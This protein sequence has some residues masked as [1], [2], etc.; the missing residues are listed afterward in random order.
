MK[1]KKNKKQ[2]EEENIKIK[3]AKK[4][5][6]QD[7]R[8]EKPKKKQH[9]QQECADTPADD[10]KFQS[11]VSNFFE[12]VKKSGEGYRPFIPYVASMQS[13]GCT[14]LNSS[15]VPREFVGMVCG[16]FLGAVKGASVFCP[17]T[18]KDKTACSEEKLKARGQ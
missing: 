13:D 3:K 12:M 18:C 11:W 10:P 6:Q 1:T 7:K 2:G 16:G 9:K 5:K 4:T 15:K 17:V 8:E 14:T